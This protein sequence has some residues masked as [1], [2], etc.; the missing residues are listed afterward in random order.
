MTLKYKKNYK[1]ILFVDL[2]HFQ[3]VFNARIQHTLIFPG[4]LQAMK[5]QQ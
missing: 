5:Q 4:T 3:G 2:N 1:I